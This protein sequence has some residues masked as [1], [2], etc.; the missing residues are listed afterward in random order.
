[1][2]GSGSKNKPVVRACPTLSHVLA[3]GGTAKV[4][5]DWAVVSG[6]SPVSPYLRLL[7]DYKKED[8]ERQWRAIIALTP[9]CWDRWDKRNRHAVSR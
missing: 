7:E 8:Q 6:V 4:C 9:L 3:A 1:M 5:A 2:A